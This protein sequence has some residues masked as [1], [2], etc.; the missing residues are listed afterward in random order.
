MTQIADIFI[1]YKREERGLADRMARALI[2]AGFTTV[3]DRNIAKNETFG[4][5][6]DSMIRGGRLTL[7]LWTHASAGSEWVRNEARLARDLKNSGKAN[8]FLGIM[9]EKNVGIE[10]PVD[11]RNL[12]MVDISD[13]GLTAETIGEVTSE[14]VALLGHTSDTT[15]D[16]AEQNSTA[17]S[18]ELQLFDYAHSLNVTSGYEMYLER[19]PT[20][21]FAPEARRA[22]HM[23]RAWYLHPFRRGSMANTIAALSVAVGLAGLIWGASAERETVIGVPREDHAALQKRLSGV[24]QERDK[25][26]TANTTAAKAMQQ[27]TRKRSEAEGKARDSA[28]KAAKAAEDRDKAL[29]DKAAAEAAAKTARQTADR[30]RGELDTAKALAAAANPPPK[31]DCTTGGKPGFEILDECIAADVTELNMDGK[32]SPISPR[33]AVSLNSAHLTLGIHRWPT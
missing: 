27:A 16:Q 18:D 7:V 31:P 33:F 22:L 23:A 1:S 17:L 2:D 13:R 24:E 6:I 25:A 10:L 3:P 28:A 9:V 29:S 5:A 4:D 11:L 32:N 14:V 12:Q 19:Y 20:G 21:R 26:L 8:E 15:A 30:L